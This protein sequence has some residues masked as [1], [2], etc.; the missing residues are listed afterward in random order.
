MF[1]IDT[2]E[3][4]LEDFSSDNY[5]NVKRLLQTEALRARKS[6]KVNVAQRIDNLISRL[7]KTKS[8]K[9]GVSAATQYH[10]QSSFG[11]TNLVQHIQPEFSLEE[12]VLSDAQ[13]STIRSLVR[14][15]SKVDE[16]KM[17]NLEPANKIVLYGP[18]GTGKTMLAHAIAEQ[19]RLPLVLVRLDEL[20]S[21]LLGKTGKNIKDIFD[22]AHERPVLLFLDELD[23]VAKHRSD[24]KEQGEL[25][26]IVT[27]LL[28]NI[29]FFPAHSILIGATNHEETLDKAVW[30]RFPLKV[31]F[32]LPTVEQRRL[33]FELQAR[34]KGGNLDLDAL[35]QFTDGWSNSD[36][37]DVIH[38]SHKEAVLDGDNE[39]TTERLLKNA[40]GFVVHT[41]KS[42]SKKDAYDAC[43]ILKKTGYDYMDLHRITGIPYTTL[44]DNV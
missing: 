12:M 20:V 25:K 41:E 8:S 1:S 39:L 40:F 33:L 6:G 5:S 10:V 19:L 17:H 7:S 43:R 34:S 27:V 18:P 4:I 14:E 15:W 11:S 37:N 16:L 22:I 3:K 21:S 35:A 32:S 38:I 44:K 30:R 26:R 31:P 36:I 23:T 9:G 28:Q 29:D 13:K 2:L 42:R 24:D